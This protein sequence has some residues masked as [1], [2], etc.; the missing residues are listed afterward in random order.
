MTNITFWTNWFAKSMSIG[1]LKCKLKNPSPNEPK[2]GPEVR[3]FVKG[4]I[5]RF[6]PL[7]ILHTPIRMILALW[8]A[9]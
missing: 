8:F 6:E 3:R 7:N 4:N 5:V 2:Q 1:S 9:L